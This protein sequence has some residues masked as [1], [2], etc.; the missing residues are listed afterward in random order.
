MTDLDDQILKLKRVIVGNR[1]AASRWGVPP[2]LDIIG[3][4]EFLESAVGGNRRAEANQVLQ[5][6]IKLRNLEQQNIHVLK[7]FQFTSAQ[8]GEF[9]IE[10]LSLEEAQIKFNEWEREQE[11]EQVSDPSIKSAF[12]EPEIYL[13][14][15]Y[16]AQYVLG[17]EP[18]IQY[19]LSANVKISFTN[20]DIGG[21]SSS[22][23]IADT[24]ELQ[25]L[26]NASNEWK[27]TLIGSSTNQPLLTL[28]G[29]I[30]MI[31]NLLVSIPEIITTYE[32][33]LEVTTAD[34]EPTIE[35]EL[36]VT[37]VD[38]EPPLECPPGHVEVADLGCQD[39]RQGPLSEEEAPTEERP[40]KWIPEPFFSFINE[41]FRR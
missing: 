28:S 15:I 16:G 3:L 13:P 19:L 36:E 25:G 34:I 1:S 14:S 40:V 5:S 32:P 39:I 17:V 22:I 30:N 8:F 29:L 27:Y 24:G 4:E 11:L 23:P 41:V 38:I 35:P 7:T 6:L 10:A 18:T 37:T 2:H 31:N 9:Q 12:D 33:E 26:S 21:F 20:S